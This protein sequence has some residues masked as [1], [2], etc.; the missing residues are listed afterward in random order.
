ME[1]LAKD[2]GLDKGIPKGTNGAY[3]IPLEDGVSFEIGKLPKGF[4]L[5]ANNLVTC[6][7]KDIETFFEQALLTNLYGDQRSGAVLGLS[8]DGKMLTL[9]RNVDYDIT[10]KEFKDMIEDFIT[11]IDF[12]REESL[13]Y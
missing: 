11:S 5:T 4:S 6:P 7:V 1:E 2:W 12:W 3:T 13:N 9:S 10:Y 8:D